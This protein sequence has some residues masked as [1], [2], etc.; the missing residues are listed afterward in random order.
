LLIERDFS[1]IVLDDVAKEAG[2]AK[3]TLFLYFKSKEEL[4]T[5]ALSDL[6]D[7]LGQELGALIKAEISG[8]ELLI[9]TSKVLLNHFDRNRD[10]LGHAG[11]GRMPNLGARSREKMFEKYRFNQ[12]LIR[13]ILVASSS[14]G[15]RGLRDAEF[16]AVAFIGLCRSA[17][18]RKLVSGRESP[19]EREADAIVAFFVEGSGVKL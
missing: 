6:A 12:G 3:G 18:I 16:A 13:K 1:D 17:A 7:A 2:V 11:G 14:D 9:A 4:F 15:G 10:F 19:L 8:K 5:E